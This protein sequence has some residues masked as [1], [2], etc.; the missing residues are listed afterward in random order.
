MAKL[1]PIESEFASTE[2]AEAYDAWFRAKVQAALDSDEPGI[3]HEEVMAEMRQI[4]DDAR[5]RA[6][7]LAS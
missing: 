7:N 4:I 5:A 1:S 6:A 2:E 3:P